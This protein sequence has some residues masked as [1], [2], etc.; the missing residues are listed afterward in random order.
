MNLVS[1]SFKADSGSKMVIL[2]YLLAYGLWRGLKKWEVGQ[3]DI[4]ETGRPWQMVK[5]TSMDFRMSH[6]GGK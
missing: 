5:D 4:K 2:G 6:L 1:W 3:R